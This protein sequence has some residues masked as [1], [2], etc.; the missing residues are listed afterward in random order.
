MIKPEIEQAV[1][2]TKNLIKRLEATPPQKETVE[3]YT[4]NNLRDLFR[5]LNNIQSTEK[6]LESEHILSRFCTDSLD[7]N[8]DLYKEISEIN[9]LV[10]SGCK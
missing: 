2:K 6:L 1:R 4:L 8:S 10:R 9:Q 3:W 5:D 7:W